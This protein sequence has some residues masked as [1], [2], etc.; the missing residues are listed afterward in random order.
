MDVLMT[1]EYDW[2]RNKK[3]EHSSNKQELK[4]LL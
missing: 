4:F 2:K 3:M 1:F